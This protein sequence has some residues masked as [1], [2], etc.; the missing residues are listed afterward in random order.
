MHKWILAAV[1]A[2]IL[3]AMIFT[4]WKFEPA[5]EILHT[6]IN[7]FSDSQVQIANSEP[8]NFQQTITEHGTVIQESSLETQDFNDFIERDKRLVEIEQSVYCDGIPHSES[9]LHSWIA[10]QDNTSVID[11]DSI[12]E[13]I[14][15]CA[16][17]KRLSFEEKQQSLRKLVDN[18]NPEAKLM[19]AKT[20][21]Y[22]SIEKILLLRQA[23]EWSEEAQELLAELGLTSEYMH[24]FEKAFWIS[25][26]ARFS[27][28]YSDQ[29]E[30]ILSEIISNLDDLQID[31]LNDAIAT[32]N[33]SIN[34]QEIIEN[35]SVA[36][37]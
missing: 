3:S 16:N 6:D 35:L 31:N 27:E 21:P 30:Q 15:R 7:K 20:I 22:E 4:N 9:D 25:I 28:N 8:L 14:Q 24:P 32:W 17:V 36:A 33:K 10:D 11:I 26:S 34:R 1:A 5:D 13:D 19:L 23:S 12:I 29:K 37:E 18:G 2:I